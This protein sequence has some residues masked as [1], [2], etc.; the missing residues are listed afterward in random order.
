[1]HFKS[2]H[3]LV[4]FTKEGLSGIIIL[5]KVPEEIQLCLLVHCE[6]WGLCHFPTERS[7]LTVDP[8]TCCS[9]I[10]QIPGCWTLETNKTILYNPTGHHQ[11]IVHSGPFLSNIIIIAKIHL[12]VWSLLVTHPFHLHQ[13]KNKLQFDMCALKWLPHCSSL[14][15]QYHFAWVWQGLFLELWQ[16]AQGLPEGEVML[17]PSRRQIS[18]HAFRK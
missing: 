18:V 5:L 14:Q 2:V 10:P 11:T 16:R 17:P 13:L 6:K 15:P 3:I 9:D 1:M 7:L 12:M 4:K 8:A